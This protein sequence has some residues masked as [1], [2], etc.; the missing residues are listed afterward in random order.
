MSVTACVPLPFTKTLPK[1]KLLGLTLMVEEAARPVPLTAT[2]VGEFGALLIIDTEPVTLPAPGGAYCTLKFPVC[3]GA[4]VIGSARPVKPNPVPVTV[5]C[6]IVRVAVPVFLTCK[7]CEFVVPVATE[8][9][10]ALEALRSI[11]PALLLR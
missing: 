9:K 3:A 4:S 6:E 10:L 7:V 1:L 8:P 11:P 2:V 5:A